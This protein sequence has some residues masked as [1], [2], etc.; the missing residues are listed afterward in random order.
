MVNERFSQMDRVLTERAIHFTGA[1]HMIFKD[2]TTGVEDWMAFF[3]DP[4]GNVLS[5]MSRVAPAASARRPA[6]VVSR[7]A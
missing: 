6:V 2:D 4:D 1:P 5:I 7:G 3:E